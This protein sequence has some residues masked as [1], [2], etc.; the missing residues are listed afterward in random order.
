M[1]LKGKK[2]AILAAEMYEDLELWYPYYRM[3]EAG[4]TVVIV[5]P[6]FGPDEVKSKHGYPALLDARAKQVRPSEL[7]GVIIPGGYAPDL[8]RRCPATLKLVGSM[9]Q[10]EKVVAA[11]CHAGWVL[12]SAGVL[13]VRRAT[14]FFSIRDDMANAGAEWVDEEVVVDGRLITSRYPDDLPAFCRAIV[15]ALG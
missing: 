6:G 3:K 7:D 9:M 13:E 12:I 11:I 4:A 10:E 1:E 5:G 14:S 15:A 2:V 8:L